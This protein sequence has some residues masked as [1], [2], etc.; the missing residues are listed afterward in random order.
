MHSPSQHGIINCKSAE[1]VCP[2]PKQ[3][4]HEGNNRQPHAV[5]RP[6]PRGQPRHRRV[7]CAAPDKHTYQHVAQ[8]QAHNPHLCCHCGRHRR[9][10]TKERHPMVAHRQTDGA[11]LLPA[12]RHLGAA[13]LR[14]GFG[15]RRHPLAT[16]GHLL[17][18]RHR[19][20]L[21]RE[22]LRQHPSALPAHHA[23]TW[24]HRTGHSPC[25][26]GALL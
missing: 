25:Q 16:S 17:S 4:P 22:R 15:K 7:R 20:R 8:H 18:G 3:P 14:L 6:T 2:T 11:G 9:H 24:R 19:G 1:I 13:T 26:H 23:T 5:I 10:G 21:Q 12:S